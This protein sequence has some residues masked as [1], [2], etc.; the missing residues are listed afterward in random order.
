MG[1]GGR[2]GNGAGGNSGAPADAPKAAPLPPEPVPDLVPDPATMTP[3]DR[4]LAD[5]TKA[6]E[7]GDEERA[8]KL[9]DEAERLEKIEKDKAARETKQAAAEQAKWDRMARLIDEGMSGPEA[10]SEAFGR[11]IDYIIRRDF[12]Q[13]ARSEGHTGKG[14]D[15]LVAS[16]HANYV[17]EQYWKAEAETKGVLK[18]AYVSKYR[19][20]DLW[21]VND[22]TARKIMTEEMAQWF[23]D[24]GGRV[25]RSVYKNMILDGSQRFDLDMQRD[26][27]Q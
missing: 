6:L 25:T 9:F 23:D 22:A 14:F 2:D 21:T 24:N 26:F 10:E 5:A 17:A 19:A 1:Q 8:M 20:T 12:I 11:S 7:A 27:N 13:Q 18:S 3:L 16:M 15:E 4:A